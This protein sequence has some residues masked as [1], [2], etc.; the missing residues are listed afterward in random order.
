MLSILPKFSNNPSRHRRATSAERTIHLAAAGTAAA[1]VIFGVLTPATANAAPASHNWSGVAA[2]E[3]SG[4]LH[5]NTCNGYYGGL[6][7]SQSTWDAYGGKAYASR[8]DLA[9]SGAQVA[10]AERVL[11]G[12][13][14]G[15]WPTCGRHLA[16]GTT[17]VHDRPA[18]RTAPAR[19]V[20]QQA[21]P[22]TR[23]QQAAPV[24]RS[25]QTAPAAQKAVPVT[26]TSSATYTVKSGD[27]LS[28]IADARNITGGWQALW[29]AN[30]N[31]I[32]NPD[33]IFP[34]QV[35]HY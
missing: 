3:S 23:S 5:I 33:L 9:S 13:G 2:C 32:A 14:V 30:Q 12:Q 25:Q 22:A 31:I 4:N 28:G 34:G 8:A 16:S 21:A 19:H 35:L 29:H 24:T 15:A 27:T 10:V 17:A 18:A 26:R 7:F 6:Q 20:A 11:R 1:A